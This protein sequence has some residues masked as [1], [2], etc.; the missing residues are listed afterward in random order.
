MQRCSPAQAVGVPGERDD[1]QGTDRVA[2]RLTELA[3]TGIRVGQVD[4]GGA[5]VL[6]QRR[7]KLRQ[8]GEQLSLGGTVP[9]EAHHVTAP[10]CG[11]L[12]RTERAYPLPLLR[13][14]RPGELVSGTVERTHAACFV[15][16]GGVHLGRD[17]SNPAVGTRVDAAAGRDPHCLTSERE[18]IWRGTAIGG[19]ERAAS[20]GDRHQLVVAG[21]LGRPGGYR[22]VP[23]RG[24]ELA[25]VEHEDNA[26]QAPRLA[27]QGHD[28]VAEAARGGGEVG[29]RLAAALPTPAA[30]LY[31]RLRRPGARA[32]LSQRGA[33]TGEGGAGSIRPGDDRVWQPRAVLPPQAVLKPFNCTVARCCVLSRRTTSRKKPRGWLATRR[34]LA[35]RNDRA[36]QGRKA[37]A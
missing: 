21:L 18:A 26:G 6:G 23:R 33:T 37:G 17:G 7:I 24:R 30:G 29:R 31:R 4:V 28:D 10:V 35:L 14:H 5:P 13:R 22:Q 34:G 2:G 9:A 15:A 32:A 3:V 20:E 27:D 16:D 25:A 19:M 12:G 36:E 11:E 8:G 1:V